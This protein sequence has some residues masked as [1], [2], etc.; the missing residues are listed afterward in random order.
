MSGLNCEVAIMADIEFVI[1]V[2]EVVDALEECV[3][4]ALERIGLQAVDFAQDLAP[5]AEYMG[6]TLQQS[7]DHKVEKKEQVVYVG[8][9]AEY[10][11]YVE[12]GTGMYTSG[13]RKTPWVYQDPKDG[14]WHRTHGM[15]A[16]PYIKPAIADHI[17]TYENIVKD[18][19]KG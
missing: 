7:I 10:A 16:Q 15:K 11:A 9:T 1:R 2:D 18:E 19:M 4:R 6:G 12:L 3:E 5:V 14:T 13:G 8:A 17:Q